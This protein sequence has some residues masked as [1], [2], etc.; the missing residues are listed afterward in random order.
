[1][2]IRPDLLVRPIHSRRDY[3]HNLVQLLPRGPGWRIPVE[4]VGEV[5]PIGIYSSE[6]FGLANVV[7]AVSIISPEGILSAE[8]F[9]LL[10]LDLE[11][12]PGGIASAEA[13]GLCIVGAPAILS[14]SISSSEVFGSPGFI[15]FPASPLKEWNFVGSI[16]TGW[17]STFIANWVQS[18]D[19]E[20]SIA[21]RGSD[22]QDRMYPPSGAELTGDFTIQMGLW[23]TAAPTGDKSVHAIIED[24]TSTIVDTKILAA[25]KV[26]EDSTGGEHNL[27]EFSP[28]VVHIKIERVSGTIW[29]YVWDDGWLR[30][31][32]W[33]TPGSSVSNSNNIHLDVDG[34]DD[35]GIDYIYI[36][37]ST[38]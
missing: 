19:N 37:G 10:E 1:M 33:D 15:Q 20:E 13:F 5:T 25:G 34:A 38:V 23:R 36:E 14:N 32:S 26:Y 31:D 27:E 22:G 9:G 6:T 7:R 29:T 30:V 24:G 16:G 11:V 18:T 3:I 2:T 21:V 4:D 8:S 17:D 12:L 28:G 35:N